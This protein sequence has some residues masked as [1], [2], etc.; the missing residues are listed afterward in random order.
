MCF[1]FI[2]VCWCHIRRNSGLLLAA[3]IY[4]LQ[5]PLATDSRHWFLFND[6]VSSAESIHPY[7]LRNVLRT[8]GIVRITKPVQCVFQ[9]RSAYRIQVIETFGKQLFG[10]PW[11]SCSALHTRLG[12]RCSSSL[13]SIHIGS[14]GH[15]VGKADSLPAIKLQEREANHL[16]PSNGV[17]F[18]TVNKTIKV[19]MWPK[20]HTYVCIIEYIFIFMY[21]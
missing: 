16:P 15:S 5:N 17:A 2:R 12:T 18:M 13:R 21:I 7:G 1:W 6:A 19:N 11:R 9:T 14:G 10:R 3:P 20:S 4:R 8:L